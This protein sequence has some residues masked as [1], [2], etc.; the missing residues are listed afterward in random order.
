MLAVSIGW[1]AWTFQHRTKDY[2]NIRISL[3]RLLKDQEIDG[4]EREAVCVFLR[5]RF[6]GER[7]KSLGVDYS[8]VIAKIE[9]GAPLNELEKQQ[10]TTMKEMSGLT[11][12]K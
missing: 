12:T 9:T 6:T 4:R 10:L 3:N 5:Q 8:A 11:S 7:G 1:L 2:S